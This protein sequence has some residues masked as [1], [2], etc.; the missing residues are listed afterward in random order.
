M[1]EPVVNLLLVF[2]CSLSRVGREVV[3]LIVMRVLAQSRRRQR[4]APEEFL[5]VLLEDRVELGIHFGG[6]PLIFR[7]HKCPA[8]DHS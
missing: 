2:E 5:E 4:L 3:E 1:A 8:H 6:P 7:M